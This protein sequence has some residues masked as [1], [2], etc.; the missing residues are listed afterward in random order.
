MST[1]KE[2]L[3]IWLKENQYQWV[4]G[5]EI[6]NHLGISR[7]AIWK[8]IKNLKDEGYLIQSA[9]KKGYRLEQV[10]DRILPEEIQEHLQTRIIGRPKTICMKEV[11][12]TN[13]HAK[14][15][16]AQGAPE[17]TVVVAEAQ[18]AGRG[19]MSRIWFSPVGQNVYTS[20][21]LRPPMIPSQAPQITLMT[22]VAIAQTLKNTAQLDVRIKWPNDILINNKKIAGILTEISTDMDMINYV[23]VGLGL[24]INIPKDDLP[25]EIKKIATSV[26]IQKGKP[27]SRVKLLCAFLKNFEICYEQVKNQGFA[28]IM[29]Q[30][31]EMS[32]I[33][34]RQVYVD[35]INSKFKGIVDSVDDDGVLNSKVFWQ[36][37]AHDSSCNTTDVMQLQR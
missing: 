2:A 13:L 1:T 23:I 27:F 16:A 4:S 31:R 36:K 11:D 19:R 33:I 6:S 18:T 5:E 30:W 26:L 25:P 8:Q 35:V 9:P 24:N 32:D 37:P 22:A 29:D 17:G 7:A 34:G 10:T 15:L 21:I 12:S 20:I 28:P 14:S 3:L